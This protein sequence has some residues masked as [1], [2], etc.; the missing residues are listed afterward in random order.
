MDIGVAIFG[1]AILATA[2]WILGQRQNHK[3]T[4][5]EH[6]FR[7]LD[8][9]RED[10]AHWEANERFVGMAKRDDLPTPDDGHRAED[11]SAYESF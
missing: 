11:I 2:G 3:L 5:L 4:H 6:T 1:G 7:V 9:H 8:N 10:D